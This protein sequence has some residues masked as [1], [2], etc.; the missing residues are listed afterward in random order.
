MSSAH[1][2]PAAAMRPRRRTG[3][4]LRALLAG[5]NKLLSLGDFTRGDIL[6][7]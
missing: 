7:D 5:L 3:A 1:A 4:V 2:V 6:R